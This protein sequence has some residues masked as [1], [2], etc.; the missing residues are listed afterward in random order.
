MV[1]TEAALDIRNSQE[2]EQYFF[3]LYEETFP[4]VAKFVANRGG[5]FQDAKDI[6]QDSLVIFYEKAADEKLMINVSHEYYIIGIAKNLWIRKFRD[7]SKMVD[8]SVAEKNIHI[9]DD[10]PDARENKLATLLQL[11]GRKC[12]NLLQA[13]YYDNLPLQQ[14]KDAFGFANVR[15][16]A[17]QKHKCLEKI[18]NTIHEKSLRY[19]DFDGYQTN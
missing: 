13:F 1:H 7:D 3:R 11:T 4:A 19:E 16:A 5:S 14:I 2:R 10:A 6:F 8:L 17:V 18:R 12:L 9:P 15:S